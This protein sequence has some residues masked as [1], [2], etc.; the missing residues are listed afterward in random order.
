MGSLFDEIGKEEEVA[1][2]VCIEVQWGHNISHKQTPREQ[3]KAL[4][5]PNPTLRSQ[6][7]NTSRRERDSCSDM[8]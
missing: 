2:T 8:T 1:V 5:S 6:W 4:R 3:N 7:K